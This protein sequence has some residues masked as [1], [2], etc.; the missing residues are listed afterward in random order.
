[1][2]TETLILSSLIHN[3]PYMRQVT[4]HLTEHYFND[5]AEK[6]IFKISNEFIQRYNACPTVEALRLIVNKDENLADDSLKKISFALDE[7]VDYSEPPKLD[8]AVNETE[9]FC[10]DMALYNAIMGAMDIIEGKG[11]NK[12]KHEL[13][14]M[15]HDALRVSFDSRVG[16]DYIEDA[17]ARYE[18]YTSEESRIKFQ[19]EWLNKITKGGSPRKT[20]NVILAGTNVGKT[21]VMCSLAADALMD[22]HNV[23][24]ITA[25]MAEERIAERID[26]NC[27]NVELDNIEKIGK[28][29]F[30]N[31]FSSRV[32]NKTSGKLIIKEYP[33]SA[34][35]VGHLR[36]LVKELKTKKNFTPDIIFVDYLGIMASSR[37]K[38][39]G[40]IN[41]YSFVKLVA[42]EL[43]GFAKEMDV[44]LWTGAQ[45]NRGGHG[46]TEIDLD[47]TAES[48]GLPQTADFMLGI[49]ENEELAELGLF[50][51]IQLKN[52]YRDKNQ[53]KRFVLG[54]DKSKQRVVDP[55]DDAQDYIVGGKPKD[56]EEE[57]VPVFDNSKFGE[58]DKWKPKGNVSGFNFD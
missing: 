20:L 33:T 2:R 10:K 32:Q 44:P 43:R 22:G 8:W 28:E 4:P 30:M 1:M 47:D 56:K 50:K 46:A 36:H 57:D 41:T 42:E 58:R 45:T 21:L 51:C 27:L 54:V 14:E 9:V 55:D 13:P 52:R 16:H 37:V 18:Y 23:L 19:L 38:L 24:Y 35:H 34:A 29:D 5:F 17:E 26:A 6:Y 53:N 40:S 31:R 25:E 48:F 49:V 15:F 11:G 12:T 3:E 7:L 39:G